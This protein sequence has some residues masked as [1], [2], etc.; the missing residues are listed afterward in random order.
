MNVPFRPKDRGLLVEKIV[1]VQSYCSSKY[2]L[3]TVLAVQGK[4]TVFHPTLVSALLI[5]F[6]H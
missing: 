3:H 6:V 5:L 4:H 1:Q 2:F